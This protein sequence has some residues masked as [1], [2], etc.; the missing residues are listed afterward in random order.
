MRGGEREGGGERESYDL[1]DFIP[2]LYFLLH[3][4]DSE[5]MKYVENGQ[6]ISSR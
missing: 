2:T 4:G 1:V 3:T 6:D 5:N